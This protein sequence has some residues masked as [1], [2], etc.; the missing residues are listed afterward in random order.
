MNHTSVDQFNHWLHVEGEWI[1]P[2]NHRRGGSSG[3]IRHQPESG[4]T[5]YIKR[6]QGH[7]FRSWRYPL[8]RPTCL[9]EARALAHF[10]EL[11]V[12]V[13]V[14]RFFGLKKEKLWSGILVTEALPEG[15]VNL[16]DFYSRSDATATPDQRKAVVEALA[17]TLAR[18][19]QHRWQHCSL[20]TKHIFVRIL[21]S[22]EYE[23]STTAQIALLDLERARRQPLAKRAARRD[24]AFLFD[25]LPYW[26]KE[27]WRLFDRHYSLHFGKEVVYRPTSPAEISLSD[28][29][30]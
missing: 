26:T 22:G 8:G 9:R 28:P 1:E 14:L 3:V 25:H 2:P 12:L 7:L 27:E 17:T 4:P 29:R 6:Q 13:P 23:T 21:G 10:Q 16:D 18:L 15:F 5:L 20:M 30:A 24:L 11:G 19:H